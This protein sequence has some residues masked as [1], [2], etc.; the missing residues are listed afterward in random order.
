[1]E[2][3]LVVSDGGVHSAAKGGQEKDKVVNAKGLSTKDLHHTTA[4]NSITVWLVMRSL[5]M[6][7]VE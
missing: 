4:E 6:S 7:L 5:K 1:M 2:E 3:D